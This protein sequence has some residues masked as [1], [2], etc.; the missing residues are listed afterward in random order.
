MVLDEEH[1]VGEVD[2]IPFGALLLQPHSGILSSARPPQVIRR[3]PCGLVAGVELRPVSV[4]P[5]TAR[6]ERDGPHHDVLVLIALL[7]FHGI[8]DSERAAWAPSA[9]ARNRS[10]SARRSPD[11]EGPDTGAHWEWPAP[12]TG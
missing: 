5:A 1:P 4:I 6:Y 10:S 9:P 3:E 11:A 12:T 7:T 8:G 2:A